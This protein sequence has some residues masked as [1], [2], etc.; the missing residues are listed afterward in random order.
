MFSIFRMLRD[1]AL[2][3][4]PIS[5]SAHMVPADF[6][7]I[8]HPRDIP[9]VA[10]QYAWARFLPARLVA[11]LTRNLWP[12]LGPKITGATT[13]AGNPLR[14][15]VIF[16]PMVPDQMFKDL[17]LARKRVYQAIAL[18]EHLGPKVIAVGG[19]CP[20]IIR[21]KWKLLDS[22]KPLITTGRIYS[23][24]LAA[25]D[26][27]RVAERIG[28]NLPSA[29]IAVVGAAGATGALVSKLLVE[30]IG[31][32]ILIDRRLNVLKDVSDHLRQIRPTIQIE[33]SSE[34][35]S[36]ETADAVVAAASSAGAIIEPH[37]LKTGTVIVDCGQPHNVTED[38]MAKRQDIVVVEGGLAKLAGIKCQFDFGLLAEDELFGC[39]S[40]AVLLCWSEK[41]KRHGFEGR[42]ELQLAKEF[43]EIGK[44]LGFLRP[45]L[46][47]GSHAIT[48]AELD[49]VRDVRRVK[50][51]Q[52]K[53]P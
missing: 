51:D 48:D 7:F 37:H 39:L 30:Q 36:I 6:V 32:L 28:L 13:K 41:Y 25:Q 21:G 14:G 43:F 18:G 52:S 22:V 26:L 10:R 17:H 33:L 45:P 38:L 35:K 3:W 44:M 42:S 5:V 15:Q 11:V 47:F 31:R 1:L 24:V 29:T 27:T 12:I 2:R 8:V 34:I 49:R 23:S 4:L 16:V 19:L 40:E 50:K 20:A 53:T 46:R 9:D